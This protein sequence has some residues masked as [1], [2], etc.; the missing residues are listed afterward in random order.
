MPVGVT[1]ALIMLQLIKTPVR[2]VILFSAAEENVSTCFFLHWSNFFDIWSDAICGPALCVAGC[3]WK[4]ETHFSAAQKSIFNC[5][6]MPIPP[7]Q[8]QTLV[9][10]SADLALL[11]PTPTGATL[12][13]T[14]PW[15]CHSLSWKC[16]LPALTIR[17]LFSLLISAARYGH[18]AWPGPAPAPALQRCWQK[19]KKK[20]CFSR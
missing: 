19:L 10:A 18:K 11:F 16:P 7:R 8:S 3:Q 20:N 15:V 17:L 1:P 5:Q 12:E 13:V 2:F 6:E 4:S 9:C 14:L